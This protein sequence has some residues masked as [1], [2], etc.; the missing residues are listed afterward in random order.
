MH[1]AS[2]LSFPYLFLQ[3]ENRGFIGSEI[4]MPDDVAAAFSKAFY[5]RFL[6]HKVPLGRSLLDARNF[7]L[8]E[9]RNPLAISYSSYADPDLHIGPV[10]EG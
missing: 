6:V 5:T 3:N 9:F 7:L 10:G 2:S 4:E 8:Q 1:A